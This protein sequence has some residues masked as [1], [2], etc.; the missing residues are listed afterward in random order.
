MKIMSMG[1]LLGPSDPVMVDSRFVADL[2]T[3]TLHDVR[4]GDL[5]YLL[6]DLPP[7][8]GEPQQ[9]LVHTF[10]IDGAVVVTTPQDLFLLDPSR[11]LRL[12][13]HAQIP[14]TCSQ[15]SAS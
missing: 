9:T 4:W 13:Q 12:F 3:Q 15:A 5:E 6:I 11:S 7:G 8:T 10:H 14:R 2:V 1:F